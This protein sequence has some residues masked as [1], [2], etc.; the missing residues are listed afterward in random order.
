MWLIWV[1]QQLH[2]L[3]GSTSR[4]CGVQFVTRRSVIIV[5]QRI[6]A[7]VQCYIIF[8]RFTLAVH[9][10]VVTLWHRGTK[11]SPKWAKRARATAVQS[12]NPS[13]RPCNLYMAQLSV[14]P[15]QFL[16]MSLRIVVT[17]HLTDSVAWCD[18]RLCLACHNYP[19]SMRYGRK[20]AL[21]TYGHC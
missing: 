16:Y 11:H 20:Q 21:I 10:T 12:V 15:R 6:T 4:H 5:C 13:P 17:H 8:F 14:A 3:Q 2:V 7:D 9:G 1:K 19:C 18:C